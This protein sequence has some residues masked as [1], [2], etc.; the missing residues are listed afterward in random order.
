MADIVLLNKNGVPTTYEGV[1][2]LKVPTS[3]GGVQI[4][5]TPFNMNDVWFYYLRATGT[6]DQYLILE[7]SLF[8]GGSTG[9]MCALTASYCQE[10][11]YLGDNGE[12]IIGVLASKNANLT[13]GETYS[14]STLEN[15]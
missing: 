10:N 6:E 9:K 4:F 14:L 13:V 3:A 2:E 1:T 12:Y 11:G 8:A 5:E 15:G 7:K